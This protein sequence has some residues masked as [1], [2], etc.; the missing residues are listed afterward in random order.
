MTTNC[1][2][3]KKVIDFYFTQKI[4]TINE[5]TDN[6][7]M[8][9]MVTTAVKN[10][11][12]LTKF[13]LTKGDFKILAKYSLPLLKP[14]QHS[15]IKKWSEFN[16]SGGIMFHFVLDE[17]KTIVYAI[18][19][20]RNYNSLAY[21]IEK[22]I[23]NLKKIKNFL[24][25]EAKV[26]AK[27]T[28]LISSL[29][30]QSRVANN[31]SGCLNII[32]SFHSLEGILEGEPN[33]LI[34]QENLSAAIASSLAQYHEVTGIL[35][36]EPDFEVIA[37]FAQSDE[38]APSAPIATWAEF[39]RR[40]GMVVVNILDEAK[41]LEAALLRERTQGDLALAS[42]VAV[43]Q[44]AKQP[45]AKKGAKTAS[46]KKETHVVTLPLPP[47]P[48]ATISSKKS[49][50][51]SK[52]EP[53]APAADPITNHPL[54]AIFEI[55]PNVDEDFKMQLNTDEEN[56]SSEQS[57]IHSSSK[58]EVSLPANP[59]NLHNGGENISASDPT[60]VLETTS[61]SL[62]GNVYLASNDNSTDSKL[63]NLY[64]LF[65]QNMKLQDEKTAALN[66]AIVD[67]KNE[68][69][70]AIVDLK[71][72]HSIEMAALNVAIVDMKNEHSIAIVDLKNE[73]SIAIVDLKLWQDM[74]D[75]SITKLRTE[76]SKVSKDY[77]TLNNKFDELKVNMMWIHGRELA[78][79]MRD[80][81]FQHINK[82]PAINEDGYWLWT[83]FWSSITE[84]EINSWI[85]DADL[86]REDLKLFENGLY[87]LFILEF[88]LIIISFYRDTRRQ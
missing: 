45:S 60:P 54:S 4:F 17:E 66:V 29:S 51:K 83:A 11:E 64:D 38:A 52:S 25:S 80:N 88:Q 40:G 24:F 2:D 81:F 46:A 85:G 8:N 79:K 13:E 23:T 19:N 47:P 72:E 67:M 30:S 78:V 43:A 28:K 63:Q 82:R 26:W 1:D 50:A 42:A 76:S 5:I 77:K 87:D 62:E 70:I 3:S 84:N 75:I 68:H 44:E 20:Q 39:E 71:N 74:Q 12:K 14:D 34:S 73:H 41:G 59:N 65:A 7:N 61:Y 21:D 35:L 48:L 10:Y 36:L 18:K 33:H 27:A 6:N 9:Q 31:G 58:E 69:S 37:M 55:S 57:N 53:I 16:K 49:K 56:A 15:L 86:T 32:E 22:P